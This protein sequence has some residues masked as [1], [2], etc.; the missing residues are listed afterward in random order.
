MEVVGVVGHIAIR[1]LDYAGKPQIYTPLFASSLHFTA[2]VVRTASADPMTT[3]PE[4]RR[5]MRGMDPDLPLFNTAAMARQIADTAGGARLGAFTFVGARR[6]AAWLLAAI[7]L[8]GVVG[9]SVTIRT[10]ELG[11]R[12]ALG[13]R[14]GAL[15]RGVVVYGTALTLAGLVVGLA[16]GLRRCACLSSLLAGVQPLDQ[17]VLGGAALALLATGVAASYLPARRVSRVDPIAALKA[18]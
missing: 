18:D 7:G 10:R 3:M 13:A 14:P 16:G 5:M 8:A 17:R 1:T 9:Y 15:V 11:I 12:L 2:L 4:I 6:R